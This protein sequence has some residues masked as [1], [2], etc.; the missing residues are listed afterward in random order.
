MLVSHLFAL[1]SSTFAVLKDYDWDSWTR[2]L[3]KLSRPNVLLS[4]SHVSIQYL[5]S[6]FSLA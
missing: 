2:Q 6:V 3:A 5:V 4:L 1:A